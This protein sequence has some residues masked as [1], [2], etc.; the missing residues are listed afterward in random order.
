VSGIRGC[1]T[2][3]NSDDT[4]CDDVVLSGPAETRENS[5]SDVAG[6]LGGISISESSPE[7]DV[8]R[9]SDEE[10]RTSPTKQHLVFISSM[11]ASVRTSSGTRVERLAAGMFAAAFK[12]VGGGRYVPNNS[13]KAR[14]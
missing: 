13:N 3:E 8:A 14:K 11:T 9:M 12:E 4:C 2:T 6:S 5:D 1:E 10:S 7:G